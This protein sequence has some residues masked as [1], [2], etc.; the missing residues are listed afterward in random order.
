[1]TDRSFVSP[2]VR[3]RIRLVAVPIALGWGAGA[4]SRRGLGLAV[5]GG[6]AVSQV[7][8]LYL[9]P[10]VYI[11]FEQ[12][13]EWLWRSRKSGA[14][15][16]T[17][18]APVVTGPFCPSDALICTPS[19]PFGAGFGTGTVC[20]PERVAMPAIRVAASNITATDVPR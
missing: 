12:F 19:R 11:Y 3:A 14:G 5:V 16:E 2:E 10:V 9:T 8:T 17:A 1:M 7:L 18:V 20:A 13:Q 6:L 15:G 4:E